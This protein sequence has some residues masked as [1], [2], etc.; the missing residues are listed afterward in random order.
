MDF[1]I[2][3]G[4]H[5]R[6]NTKRNLLHKQES[7][8]EPKA[9]WPTLHP[10]ATTAQNNSGG[11]HGTNVP[12]SVPRGSFVPRRGKKGKYTANARRFV[13]RR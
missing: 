11:D 4:H 6:L 2:V 7:L 3:K 12:A 13:L 5:T 9:H 10:G 1:V 8:T